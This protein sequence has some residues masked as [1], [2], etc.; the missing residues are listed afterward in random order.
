MRKLG[1]L[2]LRKIDK[3]ELD[4]TPLYC[5]YFNPRSNNENKDIT[6][7]LEN[8][9]KSFSNYPHSSPLKL[10]KF[11]NVYPTDILCVDKIVPTKYNVFGCP[12]STDVDVI[13]VVD[14]PDIIELYENEYIDV[15]LTEIQKMLKTDKKIDLSLVTLTKDGDIGRTTKGSNRETQN[16]LYYTYEYHQQQFPC[17]V[18]KYVD[19]DINE[20]IKAL[21]KYVLDNMKKILG[22]NVY[23]ETRLDRIA[24][25]TSSLERLEAINTLITEINITNLDKSIIKAITMKLIQIVLMDYDEFGYSKQILTDKIGNIYPQYKD[26]YWNMLT[27]GD[28]CIELFQE[29]YNVL[30]K[31]YLEIY[32]ETKTQYTWKPMNINWKNNPTQLTNGMV[33]NFLQSPIVPTKEFI[34]EALQFDPDF[35]NKINH[36]FTI[37]TTN[38]NLLPDTLKQYVITA[39]QR[40]PEWLECMNYYKCGSTTTVSETEYNYNFVRGSLGEAFVIDASKFDNVFDFPVTKCTVGLLVD[41]LKK[42]SDGCAPDLLLITDD[43]NVI[44]VEIKCLPME[45]TTDITKRD[46]YRGIKLARKQL[47]RTNNILKKHIGKSMDIGVMI[48]VFFHGS[49]ADTYYSVISL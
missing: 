4:L 15:D 27:R 21:C 6:I 13:A 49:Q 7:L 22:R 39:S 5:T 46:F 31:K 18:N 28:K 42:G 19:L 10:L 35:F 32:T 40:T 20:K 1:D 36:Y 9:K 2:I 33:E 11:L 37:D 17:F 23:K 43:K 44:P 34:D 26:V 47:Q 48:F 45:P 8:I 3:G 41:D 16:M 29:A 38:T 24:A 25:Y 14:S 30:V 12:L